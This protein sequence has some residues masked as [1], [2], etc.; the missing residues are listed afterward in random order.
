MKRII[1]V[2]FSLVLISGLLVSSLTTSAADLK[3]GKFEIANVQ[4]NPND[5]VIVPISFTENPGIM[6][7]TINFTYDSNVLEYVKYHKGTVV[8]DYGVKA[9]PEE[10]RIRFVSCQNSNDTINN[11]TFISF[12][13]KVKS[14]AKVGLSKIDIKYSRGDF[15]NKN[16]DRI[17]PSVTAGGV[18][19]KYNGSNCDHSEFSEWET[20][21]EP[22]CEGEGI[23]QRYCLSC[24]HIETDSIPKV[25]HCYEENWTIE[26]PAKKGKDGVM[27]RYCLFCQKPQR[28]NYSIDVTGDNKIPNKKDEAVSNDVVTDILGEAKPGDYNP[29]SYN[30]V[31]NI[32]SNIVPDDSVMEKIEETNPIL[33]TIFSF[34]E[35]LFVLLLGLFLV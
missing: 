7:V 14:N 32:I 20:V 16:L 23:K 33:Y 10:N 3:E 19:V 17:M 34:F 12:E 30:E 11:G 9:Y 28:R 13:F 2:I 24:A 35:K 22:T 29:D 26:V 6:A 15:C 1:A 18:N 31:D 25:D 5:T 4:A 27:V 8:S 21:A